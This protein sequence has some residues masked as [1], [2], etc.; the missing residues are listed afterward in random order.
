MSTTTF[1]GITV[2]PDLGMQQKL[3]MIKSIHGSVHKYGGLAI[4]PESIDFFKQAA[5]SKFNICELGMGS[6][7]ST[8][9]F[10]SSSKGIVHEYDLGEDYLQ[11]KVA[12][13]LISFYYADSASV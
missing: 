4:C 6:G 9:I 7:I 11:K 13:F 1:T 5:R 2:N 8:L 3:D 10:L 12:D